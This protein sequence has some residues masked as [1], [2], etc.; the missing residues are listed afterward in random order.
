MV[1]GILAH[2]RQVVAGAKL[3]AVAAEGHGDGHCPVGLGEGVGAIRVLGDL[4]LLAVLLFH[5]D[6]IHLKALVRLGGDGHRIPF[7]RAAG[8]GGHSAV[9][10]LV[11]GGGIGGVAG[12][13]DVVP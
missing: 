12:E 1:P 10:R 9:F 2:V 5:Q 13:D 4:N 3:A 11:H 8:A 7:L 6:F